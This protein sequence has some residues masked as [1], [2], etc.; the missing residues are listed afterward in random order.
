MEGA[1]VSGAK[2]T[3][4]VWLFTSKAIASN[5]SDEPKDR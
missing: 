5:H 3:H 4:D 2:L 1:R